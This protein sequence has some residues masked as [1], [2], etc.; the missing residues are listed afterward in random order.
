MENFSYNLPTNIVFG[1]DQIKNLK[2]L[3]KKEKVQRMLLVYGKAAIKKLGI[4]D[5]ILEVAKDLDIAI[6]EES[7]VAANP[8]MKS[9]L[10][11]QKI[12]Q[13]Q[14]IDFILAA[15]G[16]SVI[17]CAKAIALSYK[18]KASEVW[19]VFMHKQTFE[20]AL[21]LGTILTLA[22]TGS[23]TNGN[24][25]ISYREIADKR[26]VASQK[27]V[28]KFSIIDPSYTLSVPKH[29]TIA[30]SID[31]MMHIFEQYFSPTLHTS[32]SDYMS[33]GLLKSIIENTEKILAKKDS[34]AVRANLSWAATLAL[35]WLLQQGKTGDWA[36]HRL[37]YPITVDYGITHGYALAII[38][39]A[40]MKV[41]LDKNPDVMAPRLAQLGQFLYDIN[42]AQAVI[43]QIMETFKTFGAAVTFKEANVD[44]SEEAIKRMAEK[45]VA[46]GPV[47]NV[48]KIDQSLAEAIFRTA[49]A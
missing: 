49:K 48:V 10:S 42:D 32:T 19:A 35:S 26:S 33:L 40:W 41:M 27:L 44:L 29:H 18:L 20:E 34:Y 2:T 46:L 15:G 45:S 7:G 6:F 23:E 9:V 47:G 14:N 25:V 31:M 22:A 38:Q 12:V 16:G 13:D 1:Q 43:K 11:G 5:Y 3:L 30:G 17:D 39:P 21:P 36:S 8:D 4:Y 28:P 24:T 37:S